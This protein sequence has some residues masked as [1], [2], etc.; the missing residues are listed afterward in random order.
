[1]RSKKLVVCIILGLG[2]AVIFSALAFENV[3]KPW[4]LQFGDLLYSG[5]KTSS[6]IVLIEVD[7]KSLNT[8]KGLGNY[9]TWNR[10]YFAGVLENINRYQPKVVAFD[11]F[12]RAPKDAKGD[13]RFRDALNATKKPIFFQPVNPSVYDKKGYFVEKLNTVFTSLPLKL[14]TDVAHVLVSHANW[15]RDNDSVVRRI[16][17]IIYS[18]LKEKYYENF[19]VAVARSVLDGTTSAPPSI[20]PTG[21]T[22]A[23]PDRKNL[24]VPLENGQM[25]INFASVP[26][27]SHYATLSFVDVYNQNY[28]PYNID[29]E[30]IFKDKIVLIGPQAFYFKDTYYTPVN[31]VSQMSGIEIHA[32]AIQTILEQ[33]FLRNESM[34][35]KS[36]A[37]F[38][39]CMIA[40]LIFMYSKIRWSLVFLAATGTAYTLSA[41]FFF[42]QGIILDLV[43]PYLALPTVFIASYMYRYLTEFKEKS[44]LKMAFSHYVSPKVAET[45]M[46]HPENLKL[47]GEKREVTVLFSDIVNFTSISEKLKPES[48][49]ALLNEY[50]EAMSQVIFEDGGTLDKFEGDAIMAFFGAPLEQK[51][52]AVRACHAA[53]NMRLKLGA[54]MESWKNDPLLPG[55]ENKPSLDFR[56]GISTGEVIVGNMGSTER[57]DYTI[58]GDTVNLGSRL[59]SANKKYETHT[60]VSDATYE[61]VK[62]F[63]ELREL[64]IIQVVGKSKPMKVYELLAPKG[65]LPVNALQLLKSYQEGMQKYHDRKFAEALAKFEDI[66][67]V[68]PDDGPS[69]LYRQRCEVLRDFPPSANWDGVFEMR[70]K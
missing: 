9:E 20:V 50:F 48:L 10:N 54:L 12:F 15:L 52:H 42:N 26:G 45:I 40:S 53:L 7:E 6:D 46:A 27:K 25:L 36:I 1:M 63:F 60:M 61:A 29:P 30:K 57:F 35:E 68:Y 43:H 11:F 59:E 41:P 19:T 51:D 34:L 67:K 66:L 22:I 58:M 64:D 47:G 23:L 4:Q 14:F 56:C 28:K 16:I 55:G 70:T 65:Q 5:R 38:L 32:N 31:K 2:L 8:E 62:D 69:K 17:P 21:Y 44:A 33:K 18:E 24:T 49:V 3:L 13:L 39:L 37:L